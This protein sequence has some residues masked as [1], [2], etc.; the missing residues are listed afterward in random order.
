[1]AI[2]NAQSLQV[3]WLGPIAFEPLNYDTIDYYRTG[4]SLQQT[5]YIGSDLLLK[6]GGGVTVVNAF[7][8]C[9]D[10]LTVANNPVMSLDDYEPFPSLDIPRSGTVTIN[11]D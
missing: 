11:I 9:F 1:G 8:D 3:S 5:V 7:L 2:P 10:D 6:S 4:G